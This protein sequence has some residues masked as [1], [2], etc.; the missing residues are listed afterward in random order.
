MIK[1]NDI[2]IPMQGGGDVVAEG[3]SFD[4]VTDY[5]SRS[6]DLVGNVDSKTFTFSCWVYKPDYG[7]VEPVI[8]DNTNNY[9][10]VSIQNGR[11]YIVF[12]NT[13]NVRILYSN[14]PV[15]LQNKWN[16]I[17]VSF[18]MNSTVTRKIIVN[19]IDLTY[20]T[21]WNIYTNDVIDF[22]TTSHYIGA[23]STLAQKLQGRLSNLFLDYTYRDL[24]IEANRRLFITA[25]G[26]PAD[27]LANLNPI[28]YL[29]MKDASTAHINEGTGGNF[30]INGTL[31][32]ADRGANQ[33]NCKASYF[34]GVDDYLNLTS[35][36]GTSKIIIISAIVKNANIT[37]NN[38]IVLGLGGTADQTGHH[39]EFRHRPTEGFNIRAEK[40]GGVGI[41]QVNTNN[42]VQDKDFSIQLSID[43]ASSSTRSI[44]INGVDETSS[45]VWDNYLN[46]IIDLS[47]LYNNIGSGT[48]FYEGSIGELYFDMPVSYIDLSTNN[49]FWDSETNKPIPVRKAMETLG[50][51][52]LICM[53]IDASNP[54]K[55]YGSGGDF[56]LNGGGLVGA[57]GA[58][59]Y[60]ARSFTGAT[61]T[62]TIDT[63]KLTIAS[64]AGATESE[65]SLFMCVENKST[66][67]TT[68]TNIF[69]FIGGNKL[70]IYTNSTESIV[71]EING[72][73][74]L[75]VTGVFTTLAYHTIF[76]YYDG[77]DVYANVDG[78]ITSAAFTGTIDM[79]VGAGIFG[80]SG[81]Y[82]FYGNCASFY[83]TNE[84][85]DYSAEATKNLYLNQLGYPR[86]L[87]S[88]IE[89]GNIPTPLIYLPFDDTD[90]LGKNLGTGGDFTVNG[91]VTAGADFNI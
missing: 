5:L 82:D 84:F 64:L 6:S 44:I 63:N 85:I 71:I 72:A 51:N 77:S 68:S 91:T 87:T 9:A 89:A 66:S 17:I 41:F 58:S 52:P 83:F 3:V 69:S 15:N 73:I 78:N 22:T 50:S 76:I 12:E 29:P 74:V 86:D 30:S 20:A 45:V 1:D 24:S 88:E 35:V 80:S 28:L 32:T 56:T 75:T 37:T 70:Y 61:N 19:D 47:N 53:P 16:S 65:F 42:P 14:T 2:A 33:D 4:G 49:P 79:S 43:L 21:T 67:L 31:A 34:D 55:N 57:R 38:Q 27:G 48:A 40:S 46:D 39:L 10:N 90:N 23:R 54:T 7:E 62:T 59:E 60:I 11:L 81:W 13:S 18:D 8:Y 36:L 25:D 26:K